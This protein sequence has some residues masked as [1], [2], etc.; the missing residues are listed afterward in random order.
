MTCEIF[1]DIPNEEQEKIYS[2][3]KKFKCDFGVFHLPSS[4]HHINIKVDVIKFW[5]EDGIYKA[6]KKD[7]FTLK[8][9][10]LQGFFD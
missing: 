1:F 4:I 9:I 7:K 3:G 6:E 2:L 5:C 8:K 10:S